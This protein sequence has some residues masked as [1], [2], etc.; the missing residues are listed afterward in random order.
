[1]DGRW[2]PAYVRRDDLGGQVRGNW[3]TTMDTL[4][5]AGLT[6]DDLS[7][8]RPYVVN[9]TEGRFSTG[10]LFQTTESDVDEMFERVQEFVK[11]GTKKAPVPMVLWAHGGLVSEASGLRIAQGQVEWWTGMGAYPLHFV[12]ETGLFDALKQIARD[13]T[14]VRDV[15]DHTTDPM[16]ETAVRPLGRRVW[17]AMKQSAELASADSGGAR[18][19]ARKLAAL[20]KANEGKV[21]LHAVGHSAGAI[22]HSHFLPMARKEG[23]P[24]FETLQLLAPAIRVDEFLERLR[25]TLDGDVNQLVTYTMKRE[26][27]RD[28][29][30]IGAYHKSLLYLISRALE[31]ERGAAILGLEDSIRASEELRA[32]YGLDGS[33]GKPKATVLWSKTETG[34][35]AGSRT[36]SISHGGFDNDPDTME[37]VATRVGVKKLVPFEGPALDGA[38][39]AWSEGA[40]SF[41]EDG[42][43]APAVALPVQGPRPDPAPLTPATTTGRRRALCIGIDTYPTP[44][45]LAGCVADAH[46]WAETLQGLGFAVERLLDKEATRE[47]MVARLTDLV[48]GSQP[49]DLLVLQ[50]SGHGTQVPDLDKGGAEP[51]HRDEALCPVDFEKGAL[52]IDDDLRGIIGGLPA[53]VGLTVI[54][55]CCHSGTNTRFAA[56]P[57]PTV[58]GVVQ[59]VRARYVVAEDKVIA[60]YRRARAAMPS[61][62]APTTD[63]MRYVAFAACQDH[64][65]ALETDGQGDFTRAALAT[66]A[67]RRSLSNESFLAAV[68]DLLSRPGRQTPNLECTDADRLRPMFR[69]SAS[70]PVPIVTVPG[71]SI[72]LP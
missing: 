31:T 57:A 20:C 15:W 13:L 7:A 28:D 52:L 29:N 51:D 64:E 44:N 30:C 3:G 66:L 35:P 34:A 59:D 41:Q 39:R 40:R 9:L 24:A 60:S 23:V 72:D 71:G 16:I 55:D 62:P 47:A 63:P 38:R 22:F 53:G 12:W 32:M 37:S 50:Y 5:A 10:G 70:E 33:T 14:G 11:N 48:M 17:Q 25:P 6:P 26:L 21:S 46:A 58:D 56:A 18:Y 43:P 67:S 4:R 27:E 69:P 8:L 19:V 65:V 2:A 61:T 1:M 49:G 42:A 45:E 68:A 54:T 36:C